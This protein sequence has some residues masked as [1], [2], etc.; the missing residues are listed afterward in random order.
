M[1]GGGAVHMY[2][3]APAHLKGR[4]PY[5]FVLENHGRKLILRLRGNHKY[6]ASGLQV[7]SLSEWGII[8][9]T[10]LRYVTY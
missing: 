6:D 10:I 8:R 1:L 2:S 5:V 3:R 9:V 4:W 7:E